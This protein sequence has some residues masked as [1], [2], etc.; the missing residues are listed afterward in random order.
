M[1]IW[2]TPTVAELWQEKQ[3]LSGSG[4][5]FRADAGTKNTKI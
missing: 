1:K 3:L 4:N 2:L 5:K